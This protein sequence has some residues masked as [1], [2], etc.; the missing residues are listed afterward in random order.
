MLYKVEESKH[1]QTKRF[2]PFTP[3]ELFFFSFLECAI[4]RKG[5]WSSCIITVFKEIPAFKANNVDFD[6]MPHHA[7]SDLGLHYVAFMGLQAYLDFI[8]PRSSLEL[9]IDQD[10]S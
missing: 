6:Q 5:V 9:V 7:A 3:N 10:R 2:N 4:Y 1:R 8:L